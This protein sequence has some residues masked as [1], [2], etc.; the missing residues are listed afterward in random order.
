MRNWRNCPDCLAY[1]ARSRVDASFG[2]ARWPLISEFNVQRR[3]K[4]DKAGREHR[5]VASFAG[6]LCGRRHE[7]LQQGYFAEP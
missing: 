2:W 6:N 3:V 7:Q 5:C 4:G 1:W